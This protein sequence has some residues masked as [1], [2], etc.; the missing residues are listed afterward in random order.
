MVNHPEEILKVDVD[1]ITTQVCAAFLDLH[2]AFDSSG[3]AQ[4]S[5]TIRPF[6][7]AMKWFADWTR[8]YHVKQNIVC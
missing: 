1:V 5:F 2:N 8:Y 6:K 4:K 7:T 3:Y